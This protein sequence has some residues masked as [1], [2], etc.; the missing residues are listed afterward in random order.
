MGLKI[1]HNSYGSIESF[2]AQLVAKGYNHIQGLNYYVTFSSVAK[3][4]TVRLLIAL[5]SIHS[6]HLHQL[7]VNNAFLHVE[8]HEDVYMTIP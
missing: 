3:L 1:K 4:T 6:W 2:K 7:G 8:L 5:A